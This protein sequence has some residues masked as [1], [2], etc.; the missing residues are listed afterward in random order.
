[1]PYL[2]ICR[3]DKDRVN[4]EKIPM[5]TRFPCCE[6]FQLRVGLARMIL[7]DICTVLGVSPDVSKIRI[8]SAAEQ[9]AGHL[10]E[11]I[12]KGGR[13]GEMPGA[14]ALAAELGVNH[15]TVES[16]LA[17]LERDGLL[18][19]RGAR[20]ARMIVPGEVGSVRRGLKVATMLFEPADSRTDYMLEIRHE[21]AE[22]G[23]FP[24]YVNKTCVEI[25][26]DVARLARLVKQV[27]ADAWLVQAGT[28]EI[29]E[30]FAGHSQP[31]FGLFGKFRDLDMAGARADASLAYDT[32]VREL[33]A[34]GHRRIVLLARPQRKLPEPGLSEQ[35]FLDAL[36][37]CGIPTGDYNFPLWENTKEGFH[38]CLDSLFR[39]TPPSAIITD[40]TVLFA[41]VEP[42]L[43]ARGIRV[44]QDVSLI[45]G[46]PNPH[47][48][49][50]ERSVAHF[51]ADSAAWVNHVIRWAANVSQGKDYRRKIYSKVE[52][53]PG[54]TMGPAGQGG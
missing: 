21:L 29:L 23:H 54:G 9:V 10:R 36:E 22:A 31:V 49:W 12:S 20:R 32:A 45:S 26:T 40:E 6:G 41:A 43:A 11:Q 13:S 3:K 25:G 1:M 44:P 15:K 14:M 27:D 47:F 33:V 30:W 39:L 7:L 28:R 35:A 48:A 2:Y 19:A 53:I 50:R 18:L 16:A 51:R 17:H 46:D 42:F 5:E 24:S 38:R 52:F 8:L 34:L 37:A 4:S